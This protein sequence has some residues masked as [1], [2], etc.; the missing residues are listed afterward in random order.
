MPLGS[1]LSPRD[2][3]NGCHRTPP[4]IYVCELNFAKNDRII[5]YLKKCGVSIENDGRCELFERHS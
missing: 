2:K 1:I 5:F 4:Y 3:I